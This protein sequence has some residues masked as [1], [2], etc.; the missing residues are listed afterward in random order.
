MPNETLQS[1]PR[2]LHQVLSSSIL[3][4]L[5]IV[6]VAVADPQVPYSADFNFSSQVSSLKPP[7]SQASSERLTPD[8][9]RPG[10]V[11]AK[12]L[13]HTQLLRIVPSLLADEFLAAEAAVSE[14]TV[15][16]T[17][18]E[19]MAAELGKTWKTHWL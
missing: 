18:A 9:R 4:T 15:D 2:R 5:A 19:S 13:A 17:E 14:N 11:M 12:P 10:P 7:V 1:R 8:N 3:T 16:G 6:A